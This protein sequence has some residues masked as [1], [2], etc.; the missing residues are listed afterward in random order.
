MS[1]K[2]D[3]GLLGIELSPREIR[4]VQI[5]HKAGKAQVVNLGIAPMPEGAVAQGQLLNPVSAGMA[6]KKLLDDLGVKP[7]VRAAVGLPSA[8]SV[9]RRIAIP[10]APD[11]ELKSIVAGEVDHYQVLRL[12]GSHGFIKLASPANAEEVGVVVLAAEEPTLAGIREMADTAEIIVHSLEPIQLGLFRSILSSEGPQGTA[13]G[14]AVSDSNI[15]ISFAHKGQVWFYRRLDVT[16]AT[17]KAYASVA[18]AAP[19]ELPEGEEEAQGRY[20][21]TPIDDLAV[22][23]RRSLEYIEREFKDLPQITHLLFASSDPGLEFLADRLSE[24]IGGRV[25]IVSCNGAQIGSDIADRFMGAE[26]MRYTGAFGLAMRDQFPT[27]LVMD[28]YASERTMVEHKESKKHIVI[29]AVAATAALLIGSFGLVMYNNQIASVN[30]QRDAAQTR[31]KTMLAQAD[32]ARKERANR[33]E[34][35][36]LLRK[37]GVPLA[38]VMDFINASLAP[39][40]GLKTFSIEPTLAVSLEGETRDEASLIATTQNLQRSPLLTG[41]NVQSFA[42]DVNKGGLTFMLS[43]STVSLDQVQLPGDEKLGKANSD[44]AAKANSTTLNKE[45]PS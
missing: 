40:V 4:I 27:N 20:S 18:T 44:I 6:L 38:P 37:E 45:N 33:V 24:K 23:V 5:R 29:S 10:P 3:D 1:R 39:G 19:A 43:S 32:D 34:Q 35:Y 26:G 36:R 30:D 41:V 42:R 28:L 2:K 9:F 21:V 22:E 15:E 13:F 7:G 17:L 14:M 31:A 11:S 12:G 8:S 16:S 25:E